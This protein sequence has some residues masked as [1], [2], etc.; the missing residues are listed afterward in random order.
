MSIINTEILAIDNK[1]RNTLI[2][3]NDKEINTPTFMPVATKGVIK[4]TPHTYLNKTQ[5][6]LSN[7]YHLYL[8]PG[9]EVIQKIGGLHKF[10]NWD[11]VILTD[12]GGFQGWS[13]PTKIIDDGINFKNIYDGS[14]FLMTPKLSIES[15]NI[16][17]SDIAM[18]FDCLININ[19]PK[20]KQIEAINLTRKWGHETIK[21]HKN[22]KQALF[23]IIQGGL[24]KDLRE[25]SA[26]YMIDQ[27][28]DG[29]AIGGLAIGESREDRKEIVSYTIDILPE[30]KP[31]YV[32]GL[33]DTHGLIDL[34]EEG[35]DL[36][37]CV[38]P[39]RLARHGKL[40]DG[41]EYI[42]IKN[43]RYKDD[44]DPINKDCPC[45]TCKNYSKA[46]LRHLIQN[47]P[48]SSWLYLTV[49]NLIQTEIILDEA[50]ESILKS[51]FK[52]FKE[53]YKNE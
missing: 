9:I 4:S 15:Q 48:T 8:K 34:I 43:S 29:Y 24:H 11:G 17:G 47:E 33:G 7:T 31:R 41:N 42:N 35:V 36:F 13:L 22:N 50:R 32:M 49:H 12:S 38:W 28:Y 10:I 30:N 5:V 44:I 16:L 40:I 39:S 45:F 23:G 25:L 37:D 53:K 27:E 14:N 18:I 46:F 21:N 20:E 6:L 52:S 19:D 26:K 1:A 51:N 2:T 3:V